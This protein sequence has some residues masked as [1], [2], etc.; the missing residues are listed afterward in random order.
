VIIGA[1]QSS[2]TASDLSKLNITPYCFSNGSTQI[3]ECSKYPI[4]LRG[5]LAVSEA[6]L[7]HRYSDFNNSSLLK[8]L[9]VN[10]DCFGHRKLI[11]QYILFCEL[12]A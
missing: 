9:A 1:K 7:I 5:E 2:F 3:L 6:I 10:D 12:F 11:R 8:S 4:S